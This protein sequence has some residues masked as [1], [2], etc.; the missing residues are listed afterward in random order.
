MR[1]VVTLLALIL[2]S[3]CASHDTKTVHLNKPELYAANSSYEEFVV[4]AEL[5]DTDAK[6]KAAFDQELVRKGIYPIQISLQNNSDQT[7]LVLRDQIE[8]TSNASNPVR[9]MAA[10][11]VAEEVEANAIAHAV[12]GF[13]IFSYA[14]AQEANSEREA[15]FANK[16]LPEEWIIRPGRMS[17]G[18]VFFRMAEG[19]KAAGRTLTI[20]VENMSNPRDQ[21]LAEIQF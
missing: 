9:P 13:G 18:F 16:Q 20:P 8:L 5:Y 19:E 21:T 10:A 4:G 15:D 12:F 1:A 7:L 3:A 14:A 2:T 17:G 11:E 6:T